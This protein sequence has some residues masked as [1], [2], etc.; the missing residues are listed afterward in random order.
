MNAK[1]LT[2]PFE[3]IA[4]FWPDDKLATK[5]MVAIFNASGRRRP[6]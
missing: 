1:P 2:Y 3:T 4:A 6:P 5:L